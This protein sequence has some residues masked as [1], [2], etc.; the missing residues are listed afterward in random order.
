MS[1]KKRRS[2]KSESVVEAPASEHRAE[3]QPAKT[4]GGSIRA[5]GKHPLDNWLFGLALVGIALTL[6]LTFSAWLGAKPAFCG[7]DSQCDLV[8][9]SRWSHLLGVPIALWGCLTYALLAYLTWRLRTRPSAWQAALLVAVVSAAVSWYLAAI[10]FFVIEALCVYCL[11]SFVIANVLLVVL[12]VRRPAHM[13]E[14]AWAKALPTPIGS[15]VVIVFVLALHFSGLFDPAAGPEKPQLKALA[16]HLSESGARFYGTYWCPTCQQQ[17]ALFEASAARLPFVECTP[18]GRNG[19]ISVDCA[20]N[21]I[22]NY[23]TWI[24][25]RVRQ[26]GLV[27]PAELARLSGFEWSSGTAPKK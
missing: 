18:G 13:P 9:Q 3:A 16:I 24:I 7:A 20:M 15:A 25:G 23:P 11:S 5:R 21:D 2:V 6:Y 1:R 17:K 27:T 10:S 26:T 4:R 19:P 8:Q 22:T 12:L 14:H